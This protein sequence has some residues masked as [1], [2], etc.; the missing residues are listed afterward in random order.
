MKIY[1]VGGQVRDRLMNR[2]SV[3]KDYLVVGATPEQ[4]LEQSFEAVGAAFLVFLHPVTR[5]EY[6]LARTETKVGEGYQGFACRFGPD[7]TLEEDLFRRD[8]TIN[9]VAY[10]DTTGEYFDPCNGRADIENKVLRHASAAFSEDPLRVIRLARFYARFDQFTIHPDTVKLAC[11]IVDSGEM[12][13]LSFER[14][15][16]E[17]LKVMSDDRPNVG[18]FFSSL[19][20]FGVLDKC[21][22]FKDV[23]GTTRWDVVLT[24]NVGIDYES[25]LAAVAA[26]DPELAVA[27]L[28]ALFENHA[29]LT[30]QAVPTRV[31]RLIRNVRGFEY[32]GDAYAVYNAL[33][34]T[35]SLNEKTEALTDLTSFL[36]LNPESGPADELELGFEVV[37]KINAE[38]FM[39][40][41]GAEIGKA[42]KQ[43]RLEA[44]AKVLG[45]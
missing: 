14:Y 40:L 2:E 6:A 33:A 24:A 36:R 23:F 11:A 31:S 9:S 26:Y 16:A 30:H 34:A 22:F 1:S 28:V 17:L 25:Y 42:L 21:A 3:D 43:A 20:N 41:T 27:I 45:K 18:R 35:R 29:P 38:P 37:S 8:L 5:D 32:D 39:H 12:D 4:M 19:H 7:V 44:L 13:A 15:W 10:D